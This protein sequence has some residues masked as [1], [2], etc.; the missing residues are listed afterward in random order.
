MSAF[1][2]EL[3]TPE[4]LWRRLRDLEDA[5]VQLRSGRGAFRL[6]GM[7]VGMGDP[8]DGDLVRFDAAEGGW[9]PWSPKYITVTLSA[10]QLSRLAA[11]NHVEFD[12]VGGDSGHISLSTGVGQANGV[13]T[14]PE[15]P[16]LVMVSIGASFSSSAGE[17]SLHLADNS[18]DSEVGVGIDLGARPLASTSSFRRLTSS[19]EAIVLPSATGVK[20]E[21]ISST[22]VAS[23]LQATHITLFALA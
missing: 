8:Q 9:V 2:S 12:T 17:I 10:G 19:F 23:I 22:N 20:L 1:D 13:L 21:I 3:L 14:I 7:P 5:M 4:D 16:W 18:D 15:G 6:F 11:G